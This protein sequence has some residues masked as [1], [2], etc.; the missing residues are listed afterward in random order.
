[1]A[2][3]V[4][5]SFLRR[6]NDNYDGGGLCEH[7]IYIYSAVRKIAY[8]PVRDGCNDV[9]LHSSLSHYFCSPNV[10]NSKMDKLLE[11][12]LAQSGTGFYDL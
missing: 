1:M 2:K 6:M 12:N 8:S 5:S 10:C 3:S 4:N 7:V 11:K 9:T